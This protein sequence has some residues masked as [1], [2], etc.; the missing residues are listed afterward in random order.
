MVYEAK[1]AYR[2]KDGS[3][4]KADANVAGAMCEALEKDGRLTAKALLDANRPEDAPLHNEFEWDDQIAAEAFREGQARHIIN[5]LVI[6]KEDKPPVRA[7]FNITQT[8]SHYMDVE[9][10]L[11]DRTSTEALL[12]TAKK[13][14]T[15]FQ[16]KYS[17]LT[18][19]TGVFNA[20]EEFRAAY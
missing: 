8:T 16:R 20:I 19:L 15:V 18:E 17:T 3:R 14:L 5:S 1:R 7:F 10:I 6:V 2:F 11:R 13:E 9:T 4:I 12:E